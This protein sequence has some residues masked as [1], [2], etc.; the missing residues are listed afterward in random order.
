[1]AFG[2][3]T[4]AFMD[5]KSAS[6]D[7]SRF[8]DLHP[9]ELFGVPVGCRMDGWEFVFSTDKMGKNKTCHCSI[10][11]KAFDTTNV[12]GVQLFFYWDH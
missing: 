10:L 9:T 3:Q 4:Q 5:I 7:D 2:E 12:T 6:L 1:M 8:I 11:F